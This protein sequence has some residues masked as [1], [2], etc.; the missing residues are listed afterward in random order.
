MAIPARM[1]P[2]FTGIIS[3]SRIRFLTSGGW[4]RGALMAAHP[5]RVGRAG[6]LPKPAKAARAHNYEAR[7]PRERSVLHGMRWQLWT[8]QRRRRH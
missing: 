8:M 3:R 6:L 2:Q 5:P 4:V 1:A 7:S